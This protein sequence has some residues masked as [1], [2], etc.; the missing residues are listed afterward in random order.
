MKL[1][2]VLLG[3]FLA[4]SVG[5]L[6][7]AFL[8]SPTDRNN[9]PPIG[10]DSGVHGCKAS[11]GYSW[12]ESKQKCIRM[13]EEGCMCAGIAGS[14]CQVGFTCNMSANHTNA[15]GTCIPEY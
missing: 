13:W 15:S 1:S 14:A 11:A 5:F 10:G 7:S 9:A 2:N 4:L 12:C 6:V 3:L 8:Y